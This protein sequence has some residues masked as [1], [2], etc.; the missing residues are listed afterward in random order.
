[1]TNN[2]KY[3]KSQGDF[4]KWF[5]KNHLKEKELTV[6]FYKKSTRKKS[7]TWPESVNE[8]LCFGWI[9]GI[10]RNIDDESYSIRFTPRKKSSNWSNVNIKKMQELLE[11]GLV[12]DAGKKAFANRD[13]SKAPTASYEQELVEFSTEE[14]KK[15][16]ANKKAWAYFQQQNNSYRKT[17]TWWVIKAKR[18]ET[19]LRRLNMLIDDSSNGIYI[20]PLRR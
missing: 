10:R 18:E 7:I 15:F 14:E 20:K 6:G 13:A 3:F 4:R 5:E 12:A 2:P 1:L 16:R 8:A 11:A 9:D 19:R 17:A